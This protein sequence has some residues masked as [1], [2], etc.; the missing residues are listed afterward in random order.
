M[1]LSAWTKWGMALVGVILLAWCGLML[2]A[3]GGEK[4]TRAVTTD[5][6][7]CPD[8]GRPLPKSAKV[9]GECPYCAVQGPNKKS[10]AAG[11]VASPVIPIALAAIEGLL[12]AAH[13]VVRLRRSGQQSDEPEYFYGCPK[14]GR[15][16]R[17]RQRQIGRTGKCPLCRR[18]FLFPRP[19]EETESKSAFNAVRRFFRGL[20]SR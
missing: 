2:F 13:A 20:V 6:S 9:S 11:G 16:L 10:K 3:G 5:S 8:C 4:K 19:L 12:L 17:Y 15:K 1:N 14:C 7:H 18:V